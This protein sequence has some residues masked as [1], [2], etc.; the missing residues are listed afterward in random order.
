MRSRGLYCRWLPAPEEDI[1]PEAIKYTGG[2]SKGKRKYLE[3]TTGEEDPY[4]AGR[5]AVEWYTKQRNQLTELAKELESGNVFLNS[6]GYQSEIP[7]G[8]YK[9]SGIGREHGAEAM[10]EYTQV[11]SVTVGM[12]RFPS[13]FN[14]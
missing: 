7:F 11:K 1:R 9:M 6:Y 12:E 4:I 5:I 13:R 10:N 8:G 2:T 14:I 3:G